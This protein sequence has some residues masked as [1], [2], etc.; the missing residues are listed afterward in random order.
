MNQ[1]SA[2]R[3][4]ED[5]GFPMPQT[6]PGCATTR[7]GPGK[8]L[9]LPGKGLLNSQDLLSRVLPADSL[10][11]TTK[12]VNAPSHLDKFDPHNQPVAFASLPPVL[13]GL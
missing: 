11:I 5:S 12:S 6:R 13:L 10:I 7:A 3:N 1:L 2:L 8:T 9:P 4:E